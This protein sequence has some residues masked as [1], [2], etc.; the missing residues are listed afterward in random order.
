MASRSSTLVLNAS[1]L[2]IASSAMVEVLQSNGVK[3]QWWKIVELAM[4]QMEDEVL[5][6]AGM[7]LSA[8]SSLSDVCFAVKR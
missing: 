2:V 6:S 5:E 3:S 8:I 1:L 7:V 4:G